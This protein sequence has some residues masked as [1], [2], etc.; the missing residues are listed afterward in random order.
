MT[1][2]SFG[3]K[4]ESDDHYAMIHNRQCYHIIMGRPKKERQSCD[5]GVCKHK[6]QCLCGLCTRHCECVSEN[7]NPQLL[8]TPV[9]NRSSFDKALVAIRAVVSEEKSSKDILDREGLFEIFPPKQSIAKHL[10][11][12]SRSSKIASPDSKKYWGPLMIYFESII[13]SVCEV[14]APCQVNGMRQEVM[15]RLTTR[16]LQRRE[17]ELAARDR[18]K[19]KNLAALKVDDPDRYEMWTYF[20]LEEQLSERLIPTEGLSTKAQFIDALKGADQEKTTTDAEDAAEAEDEDDNDILE[21]RPGRNHEENTV[22]SRLLE[23]DAS[24]NDFL[25]QSSDMMN[26]LEAAASAPVA[27]SPTEKPTK[28]SSSEANPTKVSEAGAGA[29]VALVRATG[30]F[31]GFL[32]VVVN[33]LL[34]KQPKHSVEYRLLR[35]ILVAN[36]SRAEL[37]S[38]VTSTTTKSEFLFGAHARESAKNDYKT[39]V[40]D[41]KTLTPKTRRTL[42]R[43]S[44]DS[45]DQL[46]SFIVDNSK[47]LSWGKKMVPLSNNGIAVEIPRLIRMC[48]GEAMWN[49]YEGATLTSKKVGRTTFTNVVRVLTSDSEKLVRAVDYVSGTLINDNVQVLQKIID[50]L[51]SGD[52]R[53]SRLLEILRNFLKVQYNFHVSRLDG[54]HMHGINHGLALPKL[55]VVSS[56]VLSISTE[57][58]S[59]VHDEH[60]VS[61]WSKL[62]VAQLKEELKQR[63]LPAKGLKAALVAAL[64]QSDRES[65]MPETGLV[66]QQQEADPDRYKTW[67]ITKLKEQLS[68][69]LISTRGL[70]TKAQFIDA[71]KR[72]DQKKA[73]KDAQDAAISRRLET[74]SDSEAEDDDDTVVVERRSS[75]SHQETAISSS[76]LESDVASDELLERSCDSMNGLEVESDDDELRFHDDGGNCTPSCLGCNFVSWFMNEELPNAIKDII[77]DTNVDSAEDALLYISDANEKFRLYQGHRVRVM[78]QQHQISSVSKQLELDCIASKGKKLVLLVTMD[79]KMKWEALY[80]R[81]KTSESFGKR[82]VSWHGLLIEYYLYDSDTNSAIRHVV[83]LDQILEGTNR[84]DGNVVLALLEAALMYIKCEFPTCVEVML[85]SDNAG[86]YH[87]KELILG[88]PIINAVSRPRM[89]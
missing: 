53:L 71:L 56:E 61:C 50:T 21:V 24:S 11:K 33:E 76:L 28:K 27:A 39:V 80:A 35:A 85:Q 36:F 19:A 22:S 59:H 62:K 16:H 9:L 46:V 89:A 8:K 2:S 60:D 78:N 68:E 42:S 30:K 58:G 37:Q 87:L 55:D 10:P 47:S 63:N 7:Y 29:Q 70:I 66:L 26:D 31:S 17:S 14:Y 25:K 48:D 88:I 73:T 81:E 12:V 4:A 5:E 57:P 18:A 84:Q 67:K 43:V 6:I 1:G 13:E 32:D 74:S 49:L 86:C 38:L 51:L 45:V 82:G 77:D 79:F 23:S 83:K 65:S 34:P 20:Q 15:N 40:A 41:Q 75:R 72:A 54:F 69:R 3:V 52:D 44:T 64:E